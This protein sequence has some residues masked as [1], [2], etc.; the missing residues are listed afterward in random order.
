MLGPFGL[1]TVLIR[2]EVDCN[3]HTFCIDRSEVESVN[4][5][6]CELPSAELEKLGLLPLT[7]RISPKEYIT[8]TE[9]ARRQAMLPRTAI[10]F[11]YAYQCV[12]DFTQAQRQALQEEGMLDSDV[13]S[14]VSMGGFIYLD[15]DDVPVGARALR[16][17]SVASRFGTINLPPDDNRIT[18]PV[19]SPELLDG[20]GIGL[21]TDIYSFGIVMWEC[22][23]RR[24]A[25]RKI[26]SDCRACR[27]AAHCTSSFAGGVFSK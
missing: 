27:R 25:W 11:V 9:G 22:F 3:R 17:H 23:T 6:A 12:D 7:G 18:A 19:A 1:A 14:F 4:G 13:I 15:A 10:S 21:E 26:R 24:E 8:L 20:Q 5:E 2:P 16:I